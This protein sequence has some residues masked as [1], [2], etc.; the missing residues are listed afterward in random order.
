MLLPVANRISGGGLAPSE[1]EN[2]T[3]AITAEMRR[4]GYAARKVIQYAG[5]KVIHREGVHSTTID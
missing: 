5:R 2:P 3:P 4:R 1:I